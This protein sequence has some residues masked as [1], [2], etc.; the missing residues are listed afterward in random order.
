VRENRTNSI[1]NLCKKIF[2]Y[3]ERKSEKVNHLLHSIANHERKALKFKQDLLSGKIDLSPKQK[4][5]VERI[6]R[7]IHLLGDFRNSLNEI[8]VHLNNNHDIVRVLKERIE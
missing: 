4:H 3:L 2:H 5:A 1:R 6:A 8:L 7:D